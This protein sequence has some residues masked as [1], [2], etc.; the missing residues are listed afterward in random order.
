LKQWNKLCVIRAQFVNKS[1]AGK[2]AANCPHGITGHPQLPQ[3]LQQQAKHWGVTGLL[4]C[5]GNDAALLA[6]TK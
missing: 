5:T 1:A 3:V 4:I 6:T 2:P